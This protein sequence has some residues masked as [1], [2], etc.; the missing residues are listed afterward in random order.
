MHCV[1][2]EIAEEVGVLLKHLN[3]ASGTGEE[4][5]GHDPGGP[6]ADYDEVEAASSF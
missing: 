2:A 4:Q 3:A 1:T 6:T 5:A